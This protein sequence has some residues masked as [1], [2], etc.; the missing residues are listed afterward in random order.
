MRLHHTIASVL[1]PLLALAPLSGVRAQRVLTLEECVALARAHNRSLTSGDLAISMAEEQARGAAASRLPEISATVMAFQA[2]DKIVKA[3]GT[4]PEELAALAQVNPAFGQMAGQPY[5]VHEMTR[6]WGATVSAMMPLYTGGK[7]NTGLKLARVQTRVATLQRSMQEKDVVQKV[8]EN[9][10]QIAS[11]RYNL[12]TLDAAGRQL[13]AVRHQ[14]ELFVSAGVTTR[15]AL[16]KVQHR[17]TELA[18]NRLRV[19][20]GERLLRLLLAQQIG[21]GLDTIDIVVPA[22]SVAVSLPSGEGRGLAAEGRE[23]LR[24]AAA[25]VEAQRLQVRMKRADQ[26]P[27]LAAGVMGY[28]TGLGGFSDA[29]SRYVPTRMT[30]ALALATLSIPISAWWGSGRHAVRQQR[31]ALRQAENDLA[32]AREQLQIDIES[33]WLSLTEAHKQIDLARASVAEADENYRMSE[34]QWRMGTETIADLLDAETLQRQAA[35]ELAAALATYHIRLADY[36]RKTA[37]GK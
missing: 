17:Q 24:L 19:E 36:Q 21:A 28:H 31:Y 25:N 33:A 30:N 26:L 12:R 8:T 1:L 20:N 29:A 23:E 10:W 35:D 37:G 9:Y 6:A 27:T 4:Y 13:E 32:D 3:D 11:L 7:I 14:V 22:D 16:L 18:S 5:S 15:N 34:Q 2:F